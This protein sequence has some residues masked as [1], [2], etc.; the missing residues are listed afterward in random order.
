MNNFRYHLWIVCFFNCLLVANAQQRYYVSAVDEYDRS[1][2]IASLEGNKTFDSLF[3]SNAALKY[4]TDQRNKG[5]AFCNI[6]SI[7]FK[8]DNCHLWIF[9]GKQY[10]LAVVLPESSVED[11]KY[12][13][14]IALQFPDS[15]FFRRLADDW[16]K[17][18]LNNG[19]PFARAEIH[20]LITG[21]DSIM[22][23]LHIEKGQ[24]ITFDTITLHGSLAISPTFLQHY[25]DILQG[26]PY[27]QNKVN[28]LVRLLSDLNFAATDSLPFVRF[29]GEK[30][31]VHLFL[32]PKPASRF[33][34]ILGL[35]PGQGDKKGVSVNGELSA[36]LVN[37]L[38]AGE[39]IS[40]RI[41]RLS[42]EDQQLFLAASYPYFLSTRFG[43]DGA[44]DL[45]RNRN[46]SIDANSIFGIQY[47]IN[48]NRSI[49]LHW[50]RKTSRLIEVDTNVLK[51]N[52]S[53][54][55]QLDFNYNGFALSFFNRKLDYRFNPRRG[56]EI[57][58]SINAGFR[59]VAVN[60][61]VTAIKNGETDFSSAYDSLRE[62]RLQFTSRAVASLFLPLQNWAAFRFQLN[63]AFIL[64]KNFVLENESFRIGGTRLMRGF[65]ELSILSNGYAVM[66]SEFKIILDRNS[67]LSFPFVDV[68][69]IKVV[70][71]KSTTWKTAAGIGL[72]LNFSTKAGIFNF[73]I[74]AGN[75]FSG[76]PGFANTKV[77]FGYLNLF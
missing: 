70:N 25:L 7:S 20:N 30:A 38:S 59:K 4:V 1:I 29:T 21:G 69:R 33:D 40:L 64:Q 26:D 66:S 10:K 50:N 65:N 37:R 47:L 74:A 12:D 67:Y 75:E 63:A 41:K 76:L 36:D 68:G 17:A 57:E 14:P 9:T 2:R 5:F 72:G 56:H 19:Y 46:I 35:V 77:H 31:S 28:N 43:L 61:Q 3:I 15:I 39:S 22:S 23:K 53:L 13:R 27:N 73:S 49:R 16:L 42:L 51:G 18:Y 62:G 54:P 71:E 34:F 45:N 55:A 60:P 52:N 48:G 32:R 6:D 8:S 44:F 58:L 24:Y 11:L